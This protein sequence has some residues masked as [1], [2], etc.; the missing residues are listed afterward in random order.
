MTLGDAF[1]LGV[2]TIL[3][4][5]SAKGIQLLKTLGIPQVTV[6]LYANE[7]AGGWGW[8]LLDS[9]RVRAGCKC[10]QP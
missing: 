6:F 4:L 10:V 9:L 5:V 7:M 8:G 3:Y 1:I 2:V